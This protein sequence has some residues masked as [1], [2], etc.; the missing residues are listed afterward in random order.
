MGTG[1]R[2]ALRC[3]AAA[4]AALSVLGC[5]VGTGTGGGGGRRSEP[6]D[7][8]AMAGDERSAVSATDAYWRAHFGE[9]STRPYRSPQV[10]GG[11]TDRDGPA[12]DG[13]PPVAFNAF[14][15]LP[16]DFL[17][18]DENLMAAG[19]QRIGDAWVYLII[20]HEWG[21]AI[22]ARL[23]RGQVSVAAELQADCFAG[24]TLQ[25]AAK[26]G[27]LSIEP[28]DAQEL[29]ETLSAVADDYP[30]TSERDHGDARQRISAFNRGASG[31]PASCTT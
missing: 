2:L 21:H 22:Q 28:G 23:D 1:V 11:Y 24:A 13:N 10:A 29:S 12:C 3:G 27:L 31:G 16:G 4:V 30:W 19:Y 18:W 20:A 17:A 15:C 5:V 6:V 26:D 8:A 9:L 25:G 7:R 14:Y